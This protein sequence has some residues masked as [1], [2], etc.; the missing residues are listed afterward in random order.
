MKLSV[1]RSPWPQVFRKRNH[2]IETSE[3]TI[4]TTKLTCGDQTEKI[5]GINKATGIEY[6]SLYVGN[7]HHSQKSQCHIP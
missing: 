4:G 5:A 3:E 7:A 6:P 2:G 1:E